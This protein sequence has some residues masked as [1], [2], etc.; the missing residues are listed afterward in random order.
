MIKII[1]YLVNMNI[2]MLIIDIDDINLITLINYKYKYYVDT[3]LYK[4]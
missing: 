1:N 2:I 4:L 3:S